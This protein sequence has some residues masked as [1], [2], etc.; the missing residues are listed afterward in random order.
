[1]GNGSDTVDV[2]RTDWRARRI[3]AIITMSSTRTRRGW[4]EPVDLHVVTSRL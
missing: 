2:A 1:M 3:F 4:I